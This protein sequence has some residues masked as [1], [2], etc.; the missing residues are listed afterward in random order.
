MIPGFRAV[1][2][3]AALVLLAG[4]A[5][6]APQTSSRPNS[7]LITSDQIR[8][9]HAM[10]A[11]ELVRSVRPSWLQRRGQQSLYVDGDVVVYLDNVRIGGPEALRT[12]QLGSVERI[13][14]LDAASATQRW[15]TGHAHGAIRVVQRS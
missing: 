14:F 7:R 11:F 10:D 8:A 5:T 1:A 2:T 3:L 6:T 15:G 9:N 12:V 13:E 4:C